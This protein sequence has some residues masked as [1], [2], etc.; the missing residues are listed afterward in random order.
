MRKLFIAFMLAGLSNAAPAGVVYFV[1]VLNASVN[2]LVAVDV[3]PAGNSHFRPA[4][5]N[6]ASLPVHGG[7]ATFAVRRVDDRCFYDFRFR[8]DDGRV[9][10]RR[11]V[12]LC[13]YAFGD[14]T[15]AASSEMASIVGVR[16]PQDT[17]QK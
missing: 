3:A 13:R 14:S 9:A 1:D 2:E 16:Q 15:R 7:T 17:P 4:P 11:G 5:L 6:G 10:L 8:F 12:D